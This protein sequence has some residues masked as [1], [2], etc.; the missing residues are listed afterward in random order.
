MATQRP[1][2]QDQ[3]GHGRFYTLCLL[4][5]LQSYTA[6]ALREFVT[7]GGDVAGIQHIITAAERT[8]AELRKETT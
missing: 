4:T 5:D 3:V 6:E 8:L 2:L 7:S 1:H